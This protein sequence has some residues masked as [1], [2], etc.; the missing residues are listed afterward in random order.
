MKFQKIISTM[1]VIYDQNLKHVA[2][3]YTT[4]ERSNSERI[5]LPNGSVT[6]T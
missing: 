2:V 1:Y 3:Y 6:E 4:R 5:I